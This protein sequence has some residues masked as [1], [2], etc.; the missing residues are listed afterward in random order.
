MKK[1]LEIIKQ[2]INEK[3]KLLEEEYG[4]KSIGIF[5]SYARGEETDKSD[6]DIIV[7]FSKPVGMEFIHLKYYLSDLLDNDVD[8]TTPDA[9]KSNRIPYIKKDIIYV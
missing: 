1:K 3:R 5:G 7:E 6:I 8:L 9:I 2:L 4:I